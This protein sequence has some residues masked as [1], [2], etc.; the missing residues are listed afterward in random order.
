M[1][2]TTPRGWIDGFHRVEAA[3]RERLEE[4]DA[5]I[6]PGTL[7]KIESEPHGLEW[8]GTAPKTKNAVREI[9]IDPGLAE[10]LRQHLGNKGTGRVFEVRN[11]SPISGNNIL[12]KRVLH[13]ASQ[14]A[15]NPEGRSSRVPA[16]AGYDV[17]KERHARGFAEAVDWNSSLRTTDRYSH[18]H[19]EFEYRRLAASKL[20]LNLVVGPKTEVGNFLATA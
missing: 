18:T 5:E 19:E 9:D 13:P 6:A 15:R 4:I 7:A 1:G 16:F 14:A 10:L 20:G 17:A 8:Q 2:S 3:Q 11:G 12:K